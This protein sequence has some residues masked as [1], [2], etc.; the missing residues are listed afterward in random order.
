MKEGFNMGQKK[1][2]VEFEA[3][4]ETTVQAILRAIAR[5]SLSRKQQEELCCLLDEEMDQANIVA[6]EVEADEADKNSF[7]FEEDE[8][9]SN[10]I[11]IKAL[12]FSKE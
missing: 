3:S 8:S 12:I 5:S 11:L 6:L 10:E 1:A 4:Q 7:I 9:N 2:F